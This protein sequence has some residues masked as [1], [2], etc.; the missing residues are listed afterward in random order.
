MVLL[1]IGL[2][3]IGRIQQR[4]Q[5][6]GVHEHTPPYPV[7]Q[8]LLEL[9]QV[10]RHGRALARA[11]GVHHVE[12]NHLAADEVVVKP[13]FATFVGVKRDIGKRNRPGTAR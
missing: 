2:E 6:D 5:G 12:G 11:L 10:C 13:H 9:A 4:L 8:Q 3:L 1:D 7:A